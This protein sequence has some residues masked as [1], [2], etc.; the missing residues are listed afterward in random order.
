LGNGSLGVPSLKFVGDPNSGL[1]LVSGSQVGLV[2]NNTLA[3]FYDT[4]G[5]TITNVVTA[6]GGITGGF[7]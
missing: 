5:L 2:V 4:T 1:Y 6:L 7:F 3:G